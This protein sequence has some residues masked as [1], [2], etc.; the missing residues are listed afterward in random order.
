M[1][2]TI[3]SMVFALML[4]LALLP[5]NSAKFVC[6]AEDE[7]SLVLAEN[8]KA[9]YLM[10][11]ETGTVL[12]SKNENEGLPIASMTKMMSLKIVF[13]AI[14]NGVLK[15]D[16]K[17]CISENAAKTEGSQAFLD[18]GASYKVEDLIKTVIISS[19]NDSMVAL[20]EK[21]AGSE[22]LFAD[23]MN[24]KAKELKL[25]NS[26][27][28]NSTGLPQ[29]GHY[30]SAKDCAIVYKSILDNSVY[31]KYA[32][33]W[34]DKLVHP[35]GRETELTNTNRL[36]KTYQGCLSGKTGYTSEA[37][38]CLT[39]S[40][41]RNGTTLIAVVIGEKDSKVRFSEVKEMLD[42]GFANFVSR[43]LF[44][45]SENIAQVAVKG[46]KKANICCE[47]KEDYYVFSKINEKLDY[48]INYILN[49]I[50]AP[51]KVGDKVGTAVITNKEGVVVCEIDLV[52]TEDAPKQT[53]KDAIK[54]IIVVW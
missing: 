25:T 42:Y 52:A 1:K 53:I 5:N 20:S 21:V 9:A 40:A 50:K 18:A 47:L 7:N 45:A 16:D 41:T 28:K 11:K 39:T 34:L 33:I 37:G 27:F 13:D 6:Y 30:S 17:I 19:A 43:P 54:K 36:V 4:I 32:H 46:G 26:Y 24:K 22:R 49:E 12:F 38:Y 29:D 35:S 14:D 8:A 23:L 10:D 15:I 3:I 51:I 2:K 31:K 44:K 48:S